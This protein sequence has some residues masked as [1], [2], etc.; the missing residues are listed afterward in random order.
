MLKENAMKTEIWM[1][2]K[3]RAIAVAVFTLIL[4]AGCDD[5][6][7]KV[8][9]DNGYAPLSRIS[10]GY[11]IGD[12]YKG[13][14]QHL[15]LEVNI[16]KNCP[17]IYSA[18]QKQIS[19]SNVVLANV[20]GEE[21]YNISANAYAIGDIAGQLSLY[22]ATKFSV[23]VNNPRSYEISNR[24]F[25][26]IMYPMIE[27]GEN[28]PNYYVGMYVITDLL[29]VESIEYKLMDGWGREVSVKPS[30]SIA[31]IFDANV[32][33]KWTMSKNYT[34]STKSPCYIGYKLCRINGIEGYEPI[35]K[36]HSESVGLKLSESA[37]ASSVI[38]NLEAV[39]VE[40][41]REAKTK[42]GN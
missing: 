16:E 33:G 3:N 35:Y 9:K 25:R 28:D 41:L 24:A 1:G 29:R 19:E 31:G 17:E 5:P 36:S 27:Q 12:I 23:D 7:T 26:K 6:L 22:G 32:G 11:H 21:T 15:S 39:P 34:L 4:F 18:I 42:F 37:K 8:V 14:I 10:D 40:K 30:E 38:M 20:S 13:S 2:T